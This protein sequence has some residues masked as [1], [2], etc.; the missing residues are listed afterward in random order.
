MYGIFHK[1]AKNAG[2]KTVLDTIH[3]FWDISAFTKKSFLVCL[4]P[5]NVIATKFGLVNQT[6]VDITKPNKIKVRKRQYQKN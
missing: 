1:N 6:D 4:H 2:S 5:F 3:I